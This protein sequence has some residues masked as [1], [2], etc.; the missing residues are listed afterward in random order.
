MFRSADGAFNAALL[1]ERGDPLSAFV[2]AA[3]PFSLLTRGSPPPPHS[4]P[5][6]TGRSKHKNDCNQVLSPSSSATKGDDDNDVVCE[7]KRAPVVAENRKEA[8]NNRQSSSTSQQQ[9]RTKS[10]EVPT[11]DY[12]NTT[13]RRIN[14]DRKDER[15]EGRETLGHKMRGS[16]GEI[17]LSSSLLFSVDRE[18]ALHMFE[19]AESLGHPG[20]KGEINRL[21]LRLGMNNL[22]GGVSF[23]TVAGR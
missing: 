23:A 3:G 22:V 20:A 19:L 4:F 6:E 12:N 15:R 1:L 5:S 13:G 11:S 21:R 18:A 2:N 7:G 14:G 8:Q 10:G 9:Q 16:H 17:P